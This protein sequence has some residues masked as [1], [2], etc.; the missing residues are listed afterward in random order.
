MGRARGEARSQAPVRPARASPAVASA[1]GDS[2][3]RHTPGAREPRRAA[4]LRPLTR[5]S[6]PDATTWQCG[7]SARRRVERARYVLNDSKTDSAG[8]AARYRVLDL[9]NTHECAKELLDRRVAQVNEFG[10]YANH[11]Y[12]G[13][14][15]FVEVLRAAGHTVHVVDAPRSLSPVRLA[16]AIWKT[17][18]LLRRHRFD[19]VHTHTSVVGLVGRLAAAL[20]G[21]PVVIHQVHGFHFHEAMP[22]WKQSVFIWA[23]RRL[24]GLTH[25]LL[26]Q[27]HDDLEDCVKRRIAPRDKL[28]W[29]GNGIQ[30]DDFKPAG[31][32]DDHPAAILCV[33]RLECVKNQTMIFEAIRI[34]RERGVACVLKVVG[35]G[36]L[37][38]QYEAWIDRHDM[39]AWIELLGYR[40]DVAQL[41]AKAALCGLVSEKEG[42]PRAV[43]EAASC[44]RPMV[45]TDVVGTRDTVVDGSTGFLVPLGDVAGLADRLEQLLGDAEL[46]RRMGR[47]AREYA[48]DNF[49]ERGVTQRIVRVYDDALRDR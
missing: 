12:C 4:A 43:M 33:G 47:A 38:P 49:D 37:R 10:R 44:G 22:A 2:Y 27:N 3:N 40:R 32:P 30:L 31:E 9:T 19:V 15:E 45:A 41:T 1:A 28:V 21:T 17:R 34:L 36:E 16:I 13:P 46:R 42:W 24:A 39:R 48:R 8:H 29:V 23:E 5:D 35:D 14:G 6:Q 18:R 25:K 11:I 7:Q 20:A 26:F